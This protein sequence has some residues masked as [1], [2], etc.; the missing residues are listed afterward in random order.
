MSDITIEW[1]RVVVAEGPLDLYLV[2]LIEP[3][4]TGNFA[5]LIHQEGEWRLFWY[6]SASSGRVKNYRVSSR[7][8]GVERVEKWVA[9]HGTSLPSQPHPGYCAFHVYET[10]QL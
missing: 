9:R 7:E 3:H 10:R 2:R 4:T 8:K 1:E 6:P 5:T